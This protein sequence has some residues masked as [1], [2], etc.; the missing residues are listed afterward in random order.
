MKLHAFPAQAP[1]APPPEARQG[2]D[3]FLKKPPSLK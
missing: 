3:G 1:T 2:L